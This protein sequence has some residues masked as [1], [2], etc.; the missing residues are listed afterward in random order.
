M[1]QLHQPLHSAIP[2]KNEGGRRAQD[3]RRQPHA[4]YPPV[5]IRV[6]VVSHHSVLC[7]RACIRTL[8][9]PPVSHARPAYS[10]N[11]IQRPGHTGSHA[12]PFALSTIISGIYPAF[13]LSS[14]RPMHA[15]KGKLHGITDRSTLRKTLVVVQLAVSVM[16]VTAIFA[17][18]QQIT[19]MQHRD[20]GL[21]MDQTLIIEEPLAYRWHHRSAIRDLQ[22]KGIAAARRAGRYLRIELSRNGNRLAPHRH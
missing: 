11:I 14:F 2:G 9:G 13:F 3:Q 10:R 15:L 4:A 20:T 21:D 1:V 6:P 18:Q 17:I 19:Y 22:A 12:R 5:S 7:R 8:L 16:L